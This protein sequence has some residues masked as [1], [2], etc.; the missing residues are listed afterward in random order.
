MMQKGNNVNDE[1]RLINVKLQKKRLI[2]VANIKFG[3]DQCKY[4]VN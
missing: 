3:A 2:N 4:K 1:I